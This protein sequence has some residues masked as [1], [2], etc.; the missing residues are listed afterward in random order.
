M[1][2][3]V[4]VFVLPQPAAALG[5]SGA[6]SVAGGQLLGGGILRQVDF[7]RCGRPGQLRQQVE[8]F[9]PGLRIIRLQQRVQQGLVAF[10]ALLRLEFLPDSRCRSLERNRHLIQDFGDHEDGPA[11]VGHGKRLGDLAHIQQGDGSGQGRLQLAEL[12]V[13]AAIPSAVGRLFVDGAPGGQLVKV[14][15]GPQFFQ[16]LE[17]LLP[18]RGS[19]ASGQPRRR[20]PGLRAGRGTGSR[21]WTSPWLSGRRLRATGSTSACP[22]SSSAGPPAGALLRGIVPRACASP[23]CLHPDTGSIF[24]CLGLVFHCGRGLIS[25]V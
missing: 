23:W 1:P 4:S 13:D 14:G 7:T 2:G 5:D 22:A 8:G 12:L 18:R 9:G 10:P 17:S 25:P 24:G 20:C 6:D 3:I 11:V 21:Q 19:D 16:D 15:P